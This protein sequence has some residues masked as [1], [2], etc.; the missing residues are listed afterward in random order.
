M[1]RVAACHIQPG[2]LLSVRGETNRVVRSEPRA[3][4]TGVWYLRVERAYF[5][6]AGVGFYEH[7]PRT[8]TISADV[9]LDVVLGDQRA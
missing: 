9:L 1:P 8:L 5:Y 3:G 7:G 2:D 6:P 4:R